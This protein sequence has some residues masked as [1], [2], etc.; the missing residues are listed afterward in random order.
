MTIEELGGRNIIEQLCQDEDVYLIIIAYSILSYL[1]PSPDSSISA[2]TRYVIP[3]GYPFVY[4][5]FRFLFFPFPVV[6]IY[7]HFSR[8]FHRANC[9]YLSNGRLCL[10]ALQVRIPI[11][12]FSVFCFE[13]GVVS[14]SSS[15]MVQF[16]FVVIQKQ[17]RYCD[18]QKIS[19]VQKDNY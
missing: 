5:C 10:L 16:Y 2:A 7:Y 18:I 1:R 4:N 11:T 6:V 13:T 3:S 19:T 12:G 15:Q 14:Y 8:E 17:Q 9:E